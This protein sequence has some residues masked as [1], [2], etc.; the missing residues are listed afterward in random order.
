VYGG[1][2][3]TRVLNNLTKK[4]KCLGEIL[5]FWAENRQKKNE[6]KQAL[7]RQQYFLQERQRENMH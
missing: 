5:C 3:Q 6:T 1:G 4:S 2:L 7:C